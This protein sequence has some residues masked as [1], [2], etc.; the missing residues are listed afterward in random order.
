M[1]M[2]SKMLPRTKEEISIQVG[3][4]LHYIVETMLRLA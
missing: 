3:T 1:V 4:S 2:W